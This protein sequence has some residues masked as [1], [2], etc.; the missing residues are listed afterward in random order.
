MRGTIE[1]QGQLVKAKPHRAS[2]KRIAPPEGGRGMVLDFS[3]KSRGRMLEKVAR[4]SKKNVVHFIT[5]TFDDSSIPHDTIELQSHLRAFWEKM[6]RDY[7]ESS[8]IWRI[9]LKPRQSG[10]YIGHVVPHVHILL[11]GASLALPRRDSLHYSGDA[12]DIWTRIVTRNRP[13][14][15]QAVDAGWRIRCDHK[16]LVGARGVMYYVSKY[17]A[18]VEKD[19]MSKDALL[20]YLPY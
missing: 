9:E 4:L 11:W 17:C 6:R 20:V 3:R 7:P 16:E 12:C 5:F 13:E 1:F 10:V 8:A 18:K 2:N 19:E 14:M 15:K